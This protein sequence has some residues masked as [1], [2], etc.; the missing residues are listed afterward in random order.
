MWSFKNIK[1]KDAESCAPSTNESKI[2]ELSEE[3]IRLNELITNYQQ[4][5]RVTGLEVKN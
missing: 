1:I 3:N 2:K 4:K 5:L